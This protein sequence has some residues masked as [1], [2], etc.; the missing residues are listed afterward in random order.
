M[1]PDAHEVDEIDLDR[2]VALA[3]D[4]RSW[5]ERSSWH[6][7]A[8]C[9]GDDTEAF[10]GRE[11]LDGTQ[12]ACC[13]S[14]PVRT[15]CAIDG[16]R[17]NLDGTVA[18]R[19]DELWGFH[20]GLGSAE[21][22]ELVGLVRDRATELGVR[23][24]DDAAV[25]GAR[26]VDLIDNGRSVSWIADDLFRDVEFVVDVVVV[27]LAALRWSNRAIAGVLDGRSYKWVERRC[28]ALGCRPGP[29]SARVIAAA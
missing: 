12:L 13:R 22:W 20:G 9:V 7:Q 25:V 28:R 4:S 10:F 1:W 11:Q 18:E 19:P 29:P 15:E 6:V 27:E 8:P 14:C 2:A 23:L 26:V 5:R 21:R 24:H 16:V 3:A 17:Q